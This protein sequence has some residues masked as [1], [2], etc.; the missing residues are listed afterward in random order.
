MIDFQLRRTDGSIARRFP[1][2]PAPSKAATTQAFPVYVD[3]GWRWAPWGYFDRTPTEMRCKIKRV[4]MAGAA[5]DK[6][7]KM[8]Y[9]NGLV[10]V[11]KSDLEKGETQLRR[12]FDPR[13]DAFL[14]RNRVAL[15]W[16]IAQC[17]DY[18]LYG[19]TFTEMILN[20]EGT[21]IVELYHKPA[22]HCR[23]S[24]QDPNDLKIR[25]VG[26]SPRF[27]ESPPSDE[28]IS[29]I[30]LYRYAEHEQFFAGLRG[31][32]FVWASYLPTP[33]MLYY[34]EV[35]WA[36]L[37]QEKGWLDV[38]ANV[39]R[40]VH[41]MQENQISIKYMVEISEEYFKL[42]H[43]DWFTYTEEQRF[44]AFVKKCAEIETHLSGTDNVLRSFAYMVEED[45]VTGQK[46]GTISITPL[47]DK[48]KT[49]TWVPS[50][51]TADAQ[52]VQGLGLHPSQVGLSPEGGK[53]GA[54]S[55]SDQRESF[56]TAIGLNTMEQDIILEALNFVMAYNGWPY[57]FLIDHTAHTT[58]NNSENGLVPSSTTTTVQ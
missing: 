34:P 22:E 12:A 13:V 58:T 8:M 7:V 56:N 29:W 15:T 39:P 49:D 19:L 17:Y 46:R 36:A 44:D 20:A 33:G 41:S 27:V 42:R 26:Y 32:K 38:S 10:Y 25:W 51:A 53:M 31:R 2:N 3:S 57:Q 45:A 47:D 1:E 23:F 11:K 48:A 50:S 5:L 35:P 55:G 40:I 24:R 54:G 18:R 9:G 52:I 4:P 28:F 21:E 37:F 43:S 6:L 30:P 16:Y 14:R